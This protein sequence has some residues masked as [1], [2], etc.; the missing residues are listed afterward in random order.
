MAKVRYRVILLASDPQDNVYIKR[1]TYILSAYILLINGISIIV[2]LSS[3][4]KTWKIIVANSIWKDAIQTN[5][6]K[7]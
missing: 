3:Y 2:I 4:L 6:T 1:L 7:V 5:G